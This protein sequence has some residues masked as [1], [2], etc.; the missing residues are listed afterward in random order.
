MGPEPSERA[1]P[2][3][4]GEEVTRTVREVFGQ[5]AI[6]KVAHTQKLTQHLAEYEVDERYRNE[7]SLTI[8]LMGLLAEETV[9]ALHLGRLGKKKVAA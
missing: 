4:Y 1:N 6:C 7:E 8:S 3:V 5:T 9:I 2:D